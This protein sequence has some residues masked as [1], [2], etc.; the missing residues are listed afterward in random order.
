MNGPNLSD[1]A[2][3]RRI[4]VLFFMIVC[5]AGGILSYLQLGRQEDPDFTIRTMV[6]QTA[7]PGASLADT[8]LQV[9]DRIERKLQ[10]T[11]DL[12]YVRSYTRPG[13]SVIFVNLRESAPADGIQETWYQVRKKVA[14]IGATLP[15]GIQGPFFDDEFGDVFGVVY[16]LTVDGFS[17]REARDFAQTARDAFLTVAD[18]GKVE[19]F[20]Q[21]AEKIYLNFS[22]AKLSALGLN[23]NQV[24]AAIADQNA[25]AP[26]GV[27][28]TDQENVLVEVSGALLTVE[29]VEAI[30]L[31]INNRFYPLTE[32][33]QVRH[34]YADPPTKMFRVNGKPAIGIAVSMRAGGN[35]LVFGENIRAVA[36][37]LQQQFPIGV[38]LV[39]VAD[40]PAI[41][42]QAIGGFT[43]ALFEAIAI[44]LAVS[45]ISLGAR[46]GLVVALSIPLVLSIVFLGMEIMGIGLQRVSLG[47]LIIALGLLVD[48]A[49]ITIE[50]MVTRIEAGVERLKAAT[51]AY[52]S[53]AFPML[54]GTLVTL[55]G[56]LPIGF[57]DS[58]VGEY[59]FSLFAVMAMALIASWF[60]AVLFSPVIGVAVLPARIVARRGNKGG[61]GAR[62]HGGF[63]HILLACMRHRALTIAATIAV[64]AVAVFGQGLIQRQFF[65]SSDRPELLVTMT[66]PKDASIL[67]TKAQAEAV[68]T[69]IA[70][71]PDID[72]YSATVGGGAVR[73]YLPLDVQL[74]ND[75]LA[76]FVIV[77]KGL[78][79]RD[80]LKEKLDRIFATGFDNVVARVSYL[81]LGPPVGWP[82]QYRVSAT[83]IDEARQ[84]ADRVA[85]ILRAS[86]DTRTV[87]LDWSEKAKTVRLVLNQ[88]RVRQL[89]FSSRT[90][91][92]LLYTVFNGA[93][94]TQ[95]RDSIYLVDL[96]ARAD[97]GERLSLD[98]L[99]R[100]QISLPTGTS[101]PLSELATL[102]Y[103]LDDTYVW[104]RDRL[105][106]ITVQ[107]DTAGGL[108]APTVYQRLEAQ[109]DGIRQGL[110][111]GAAIVEGGTVEESATSN[112]S[113]V[114]KVPLMAML[115][116]TV[117]MIQLQ[118]F[119]RLFLVVSVAPL[120]AIG[121]VAALMLTGSP[122]G[123][124]AILGVIAL[125]GMIIR[126]SVILVDQVE[127]NRSAGLDPWTAV[128][129]AAMSRLRPILLTAAAAILGMVPIMRDVFWGPMAF[130]IVGGLAGATLLTLL[131]LPAL[132]VAWFRVGEHTGTNAA[133][134]TA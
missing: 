131:F 18:T 93:P 110:P 77:T 120:G 106:T 64:F 70:D 37:K 117:L 90:L 130:T 100:L 46:A 75:F 118:S 49:M 2:V 60:V 129:E 39:Q 83:T 8:M 71:D 6:V 48:D 9:T 34:G 15:Q 12:D 74:D 50:M 116:L 107:A 17:P 27:I 67:A 125:I 47:A 3:R 108:Q 19:I 81:E 79:Q 5:L 89:G 55:L 133:P 101:V 44:V 59:C 53:T 57:A 91:S 52:T 103:T 109:I 128:V 29:S 26:A 16:G 20:G 63:R 112:A 105:P 54:T 134:A 30:N 61:L 78:E 56:F 76:Q 98:T 111:A 58:N 7:W 123:F 121:I 1:W 115:M 92:Q 51:Y 124:V 35:N 104:R 82:V 25:V 127:R 119:Q 99:R 97:A 86:P 21:Q 113:L 84:I 23:F 28:S 33:A 24:L 10:E 13:L 65:P 68:E 126:N 38:D 22:P 31:F 88:D 73:F 102:D 69:L 45:F 66:L 85:A 62:L 96:V 80:R 32:L 114:A 14:D 43:E 132:Y 42:K 72:H 95:I 41:V 11:P 94:V 122:L 4:L 40:Q 36:A 87:N